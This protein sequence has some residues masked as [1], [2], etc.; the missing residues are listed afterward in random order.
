[1]H[2]RAGNILSS[3]ELLLG[4]RGQL[5]F[6][7]AEAAVTFASEILGAIVGANGTVVAVVV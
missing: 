4:V 5:A 1:M 3:V 7:F 2:P 6:A